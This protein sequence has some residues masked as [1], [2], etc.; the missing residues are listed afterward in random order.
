MRVDSVLPVLPVIIAIIDRFRQFI[1][2]MLHTIRV[3][4][5]WDYL[6]FCQCHWL[7]MLMM[8]I[9]FSLFNWGFA[10][11][12]D[13][14]KLVH[15]IITGHTTIDDGLQNMSGS[16]SRFSGDV[17]QNNF[18]P[19]DRTGLKQDKNILFYRCGEMSR[20][21][22]V[23]SVTQI[24]QPNN[25]MQ[26][27]IGTPTLD[28]SYHA[29]SSTGS[30]SANV[31]EFQSPAKEVRMSLQHD[32]LWPISSLTT[33][34]GGNRIIDLLQN[35]ISSVEI[36]P[37]ETRQDMVWINFETNNNRFQIV[38]APT[39]HYGLVYYKVSAKKME[40]T[41]ETWIRSARFSDNILFP[42]EIEFVTKSSILPSGRNL[43]HITVESINV[44]DLSLFKKE[45]F[46]ELKRN[47]V[48]LTSSND[49]KSVLSTEIIAA[50]EDILV[51]KGR[52]FPINQ[53]ETEFYRYRRLFLIFTG[54]LLLL[55][56]IYFL[57]I[58][59]K[60]SNKK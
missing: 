52:G 34:S 17:S 9:I 35:E 44:T 1:V 40:T 19:F 24:N 49:G 50:P 4:R 46:K 58:K 5:W 6:N 45:T 28:Y 30:P 33:I 59:T 48:I 26:I 39:D 8:I 38:L 42:T 25:I 57:Y 2:I 55:L 16:I 43:F 11:E 23:D 47:Y 27:L 41:I 60:K 21:D 7:Y 37:F 29:L 15:A 56:I 32:F 54:N 10:T 20:L 36:K 12:T 3:V 22:F 51:Q 14:S 53:P 13:K 18:Q 31:M